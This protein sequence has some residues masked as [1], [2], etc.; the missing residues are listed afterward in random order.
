MSTVYYGVFSHHTPTAYVL[1][2]Q[3]SSLLDQFY[4]N[5]H[6]K[7]DTAHYCTTVTTQLSTSTL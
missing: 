6:I 7:A 2:N 4:I 1:V 5:Q 3:V